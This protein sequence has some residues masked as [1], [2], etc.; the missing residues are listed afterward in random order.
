M[1]LYDCRCMITGVSLKGAKAALVPLES[2]DS[3]YSPATLA[4]KGTY[5]REGAIDAIREN[6]NTALVLRFF[7]KELESGRYRVNAEYLEICRAYPIEDVEQLLVGFER[8]INDPPPTATFDGRP[9]VFALISLRVWE[10]IVRAAPPPEE[11]APTLFRRVF[12]DSAIAEGVYDGKLKAVSGPLGELA[13]ISAFLAD[14]RLAWRPADDVS[15]HYSEE[16]L[17]Y[18]AEARD[19]FSDSAAV[20]QGLKRYTREVGGLLKDI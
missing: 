11:P 8:N 13:A 17:E 5:N 4:I 15:Q 2:K 19:A 18:L 14:R 12:G 10:E 7:L 3:T 6:A 9:V 16:M 20:Q 1:G